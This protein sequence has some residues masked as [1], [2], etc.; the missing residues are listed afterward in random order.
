VRHPIQPLE[1]EEAT[2]ARR[3]INEFKELKDNWD[4]Y[5]ASSIS[6]QTRR[7]ARQLIDIIEA[8]PGS[9][10]IPE[11]SPVPSGTIAFEWEIDDTVVYLEIGNTRFSGY[12]RTDSPGTPLSAA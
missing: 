3:L 10:P 7:N 2:V 4:G 8:T 12:I 9:L 1:L 5:G 6:D 11:I